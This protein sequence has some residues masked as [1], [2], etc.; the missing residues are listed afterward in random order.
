MASPQIQNAREASPIEK[1]IK[2]IWSDKGEAIFDAAQNFSFGDNLDQLIKS[3]FL[4]KLNFACNAKDSLTAPS[5][6]YTAGIAKNVHAALLEMVNS[7]HL[8]AKGVVAD[9]I[10]LTEEISFVLD[11]PSSTQEFKN[12]LDFRLT[13]GAGNEKRLLAACNELIKLSESDN[14]HDKKA[15]SDIIETLMMRVEYYPIPKDGIIALFEAT[16]RLPL[17]LTPSLADLKSF[18]EQSGAYN[19]RQLM[20]AYSNTIQAINLKKRCEIVRKGRFLSED[21]IDLIRDYNKSSPAYK[22]LLAAV[23]DS[24]INYNSQDR[25]RAAKFLSAKPKL[26]FDLLKSS[27]EEAFDRNDPG[28]S[29]ILEVMRMLPRQNLRLALYLENLLITKD[30]DLDRRNVLTETLDKIP[31]LA[32]KMAKLWGMLKVRREN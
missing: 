16:Q 19:D 11:N 28:A 2:R 17:E 15:A 10:S 6:I 30:T 22:E 31:K 3:D 29:R 26:A 4:G 32:L 12:D 25:E 21:S 5:I 27:F 14:I 13:S 9:L 23:A 7:Q 20:V 8:E 24:C 18:V 1:A